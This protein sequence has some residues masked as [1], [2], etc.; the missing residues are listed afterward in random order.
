[1]TKFKRSVATNPYTIITPDTP[2]A[3]LESFLKDKIFALGPY[4]CGLMFPCPCYLYIAHPARIVTDYDRKFV[5]AVATSHDLEV[6]PLFPALLSKALFVTQEWS[7]DHNSSSPMLA[8]T[9]DVCHPSWRLS[10]QHDGKYF[11]G[12]PAPSS[13][14]PKAM[15][16]RAIMSSSQR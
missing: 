15:P 4:Y 16:F 3:D 9:A 5:L 14:S 8:L 12:G 6:R 10:V 13:P 2:L 7:N 11:V 1:M